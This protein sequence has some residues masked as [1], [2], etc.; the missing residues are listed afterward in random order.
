MI[1]V[2]E[3]LIPGDR[4]IQP[5]RLVR[6]LIINGVGSE[7]SAGA[8]RDDLAVE[9]IDIPSQFVVLCA[10]AGITQRETE[11]KRICFVVFVVQGV[12]RLDGCIKNMRC[13]HHNP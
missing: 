6:F 12:Y 5:C 13:I 9:D 8:G 10:V 4:L 1:V 11:I 3:S 7:M 2:A